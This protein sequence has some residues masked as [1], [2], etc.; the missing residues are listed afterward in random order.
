[1]RRGQ[2]GRLYCTGRFKRGF[3]LCVSL[4]SL[5]LL[6]PLF[7]VVP[8][9]VLL[10]SGRPIL[11]AQERVG[12]NGR[13]F[14][15]LKFRTM[16]PGADRDLPITAAGDSRVTPIGRLLRAT[17]LDEIP[18]IVNVLKGEMSIVGP[19]PEVPRYVAIYDVEQRRVLDVRPGLT[20]PAS[21]HYRNEEALLGAVDRDHREQFYVEAVLPKK[22]AL[23]LDYIDQADFWYDLALIL[24]T[25]RVIALPS[26]S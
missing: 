16:R 6:A 17:K 13:L 7:L 15:L 5:L 10:T 11:F 3:D 21:V 19:R 23:N 18:Q 12:R 9:A 24:R 14:R 2:R 22:L 20:D 8:L 4:L 26:G 25:L 1:M